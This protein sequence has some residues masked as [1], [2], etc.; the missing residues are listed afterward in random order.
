M[1]S[2]AYYFLFIKTQNISFIAV[3]TYVD[4]ILLSGNDLQEMDSL[5]EFLL[6][7]FHVKDLDGLK[8]FLGLEFTRFK[9]GIFMS[10]EKILRTFCKI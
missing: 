5:K 9:R 6:K 7:C 1:Y 2:K 4:D 3:L 8:F 10:Q